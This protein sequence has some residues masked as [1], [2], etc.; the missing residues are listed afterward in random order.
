[1]IVLFLLT[2]LAGCAADHRP[3]TQAD[4]EY[5]KHGPAPTTTLP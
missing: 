1:M 5:A 2:L 3:P 4:V